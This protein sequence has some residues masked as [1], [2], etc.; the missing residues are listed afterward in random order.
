[1]ITKLKPFEGII[2]LGN[3]LKL[4]PGF[5]STAIPEAP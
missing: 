4:Y 2:N 3:Q 5:S 1:M